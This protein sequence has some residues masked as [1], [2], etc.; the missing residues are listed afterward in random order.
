MSEGSRR[1]HAAAQQAAGERTTPPKVTLALELPTA[2]RYTVQETKRAQQGTGG[3]T[4]GWWV[5]PDR[6]VSVPE[7]LAG[8]VVLRQPELTHLGKPAPEAL[9]SRHYVIARLP[10]PRASASQHCLLG[11]QNSAKQSPTGPKGTQRCGQ[12][13]FEDLEVDPGE[14][15][16]TSSYSS[17][18]SRAGRRPPPHAPNTQ[19]G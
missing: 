12:A 8:L 14:D 11:A 9:R 19:E 18:R 2:P 17:P 7:P 16:N 10:S 15:T 6:R 13:P 5:L 4:E 1:A 3:Q